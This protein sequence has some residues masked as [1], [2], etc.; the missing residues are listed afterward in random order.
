MKAFVNYV[1]Q[2]GSVHRDLSEILD[3]KEPPYTY[4]SDPPVS[5][6]IEWAEEKKKELS[7]EDN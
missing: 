4:S 3:I 6:V 1:L 2:N 7:P 5:Q